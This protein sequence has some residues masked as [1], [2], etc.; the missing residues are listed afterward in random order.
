MHGRRSRSV[1]AGSAGA[2]PGSVRRE[3]IPT[4]PPPGIP[5]GG[6]V[7]RLRCPERLPPRSV[8]PPPTRRGGPRPQP[9]P[10]SRSGRRSTRSAAPGSGGGGPVRQRTARQSSAG[11]PGRPWRKRMPGLWWKV[12]ALPAPHCPRGC[13]SAFGHVP[14]PAIAPLRD[15]LLRREGSREP[16]AA[17]AAWGGLPSS[18]SL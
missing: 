11:V 2:P 5:P 8:P 4:E 12:R 10:P 18:C 13:R 1:E 3:E 7:G 6:R 15:P 9:P 14:G 17:A 16:Q